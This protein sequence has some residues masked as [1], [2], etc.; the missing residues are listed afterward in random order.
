MTQRGPLAAALH[1][2]A[3]RLALHVA[4]LVTTLLVAIARDHLTRFHLRQAR[5][6]Q[7]APGTITAIGTRLGQR[8]VAQAANGFKHAVRSALV[9]VHRHDQS[10]FAKSMLP[11][12]ILIGPLALGLMSNAKISV[13]IAS[14]AHALGMS[15]MPLM[16]PS[17]GAV[18]KIA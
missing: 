6:T 3:R 8:G 9:F 4:R 1:R 18:P 7:D 12:S 11:F 10:A 13:G 15:T 16:R 5:R 2:H 14:V 17:I